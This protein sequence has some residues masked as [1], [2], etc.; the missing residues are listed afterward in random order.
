MQVLDYTRRAAH[1]PTQKF[2]KK[3]CEENAAGIQKEIMTYFNK[4]YG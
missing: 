3:V 1:T 2:K 4:F